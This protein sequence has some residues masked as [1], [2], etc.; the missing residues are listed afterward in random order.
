LS[1]IRYK[2]IKFD[3]TI[4]EV[5]KNFT[6]TLTEIGN[7]KNRLLEIDN[8]FKNP[9]RV[10][11]FLDATPNQDM[12]S[13]HKAFRSFFPGYQTFLKYDFG[14]MNAFF[15]EAYNQVFGSNLSSGIVY[16]YQCIDGN[17][18]IEKQSCL[19]HTDPMF[20]AANIFL[21]YDNEIGE[22]SGTAFYR[23]KH[24]GNEMRPAIEASYRINRDFGFKKQIEGKTR[25]APII[26]NEDWTRYHVSL[27]KFNKL[28]MYEG[29]LYHGAFI[30][31]NTFTTVPRISLTAGNMID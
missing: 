12:E 18:P 3:P 28:N 17:K 5:N 16:A 29:A 30:K 19:P 20:F 6:T 8:F 11:D 21:N 27:Q 2:M 14:D 31:F 1:T 10:R 26:D 25:F 24:T 22:S 15:K 7:G 4:F 23:S 13:R 9:E